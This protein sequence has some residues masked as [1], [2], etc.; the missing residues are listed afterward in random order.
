MQHNMRVWGILSLRNLQS[1]HI[2]GG[3]AGLSHTSESYCQLASGCQSQYSTQFP[4]HPCLSPLLDPRVW[5]RAEAISSHQLGSP[6][7]LF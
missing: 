5:L 4:G 6:C 3:F 7:Y 2:H 1:S